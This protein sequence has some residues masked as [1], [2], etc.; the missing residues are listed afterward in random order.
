MGG[1]AIPAHSN[2]LSIAP[3]LVVHPLIRSVDFYWKKLGFGHPRFIGSPPT[4][5]ILERDGFLLCLQEADCEVTISPSGGWDVHVRVE[6]LQAEVQALRECAVPIEYGP[7]EIVDGIRKRSFIEI[8]DPNSYRICIEQ[9]TW[10][11]A[12]GH[13]AH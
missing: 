12:A 5:A 10:L 9:E 7:T 1:H 6:D 8:I 13:Q 2:V 11:T 3:V 4:S